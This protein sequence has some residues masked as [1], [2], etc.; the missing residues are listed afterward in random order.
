M[1]FL[2]L[3]LALTSAVALAAV[4]QRQLLEAQLA[5]LTAQKASLDASYSEQSLQ[6]QSQKEAVQAKLATLPSP[7]PSPSASPSP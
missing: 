6:V 5:R 3:V 1:K 2:A 4:T 7:S